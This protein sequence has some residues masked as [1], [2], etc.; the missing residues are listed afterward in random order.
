MRVRPYPSRRIPAPNVVN[1]YKV[2]RKDYSEMILT[3]H[4]RIID[5]REV[6]FIAVHGFPPVGWLLSPM[7]LTT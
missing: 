2:V 3:Q 7:Y 6:S 5:H 4:T 1:E